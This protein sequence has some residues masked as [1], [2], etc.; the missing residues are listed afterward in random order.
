MQ[1][2]PETIALTSEV[3]HLPRI[4]A[5]AVFVFRI[6]SHLLKAAPGRNIFHRWPGDAVLENIIIGDLLSG[7]MQGG[8]GNSM[9][10]RG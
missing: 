6:Q 9:S 2:F 1:S 4:N 3:F 5:E 7:L 8:C 10:C